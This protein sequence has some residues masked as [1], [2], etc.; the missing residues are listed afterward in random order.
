M[1]SGSKEVAV[2]RAEYQ[3]TYPNYCKTRKG[4]GVLRVLVHCTIIPSNN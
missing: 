2:E 1:T 3:E 4:W